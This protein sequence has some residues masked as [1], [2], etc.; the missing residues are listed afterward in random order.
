MQK[1][2]AL[3]TGIPYQAA[4]VNYATQNEMVKIAVVP[5]QG[6]MVNHD[7][8]NKMAKIT[9]VPYQAGM[10]NHATIIKTV[11]IADTI[12]AWQMQWTPSAM[13]MKNR[14]RIIHTLGW[15]DVRIHD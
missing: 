5:H 10:V 11:K 4:T 2:L 7:M 12:F 1:Y 8:E 3:Y 6:I 15:N 13:Q 14:L 9:A